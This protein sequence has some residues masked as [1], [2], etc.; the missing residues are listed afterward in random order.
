M[1]VNCILIFNSR[2]IYLISIFILYRVASSSMSSLLSKFSLRY[3]FWYWWGIWMTSCNSIWKNT[4][5]WIIC[6]WIEKLCSH[7][8]LLLLIILTSSW[9]FSLINKIKQMSLICI[10]TILISNSTCGAYS[11]IPD[12]TSCSWWA[13]S[14]W[15]FCPVSTNYWYHIVLILCLN[16]VENSVSRITL[17]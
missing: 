13:H 1:I 7:H 8:H 3:S 4:R 9:S 5:T 17:P 12:P 15:S 6:I 11:I 14:A 16:S 10:N 2:S